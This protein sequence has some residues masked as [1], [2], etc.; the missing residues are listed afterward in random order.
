V[1]FEVAKVM[2]GT[3]EGRTFHQMASGV[4][5]PLHATFFQRKIDHC[6]KE[7][8]CGERMFGGERISRRRQNFVMVPIELGS[9]L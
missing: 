4:P 1:S 5:V 2:D 8:S 9:A 7:E 6:P 3:R